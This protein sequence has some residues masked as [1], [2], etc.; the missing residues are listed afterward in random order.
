MTSRNNR[1]SNNFAFLYSLNIWKR[2]H[3]D[4]SSCMDRTG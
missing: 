2:H 3:I 1:C 4:P